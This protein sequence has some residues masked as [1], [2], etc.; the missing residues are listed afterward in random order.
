MQKDKEDLKLHLLP[1]AVV[2]NCQ[3]FTIVF[4][5]FTKIIFIKIFRSFYGYGFE[6]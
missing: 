1:D 5:S 4:F 2:N 6:S 3:I